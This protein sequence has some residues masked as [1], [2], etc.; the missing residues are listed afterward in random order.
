M[1][2]GGGG[3]GRP[4]CANCGPGNAE[5]RAAERLDQLNRIKSRLIA[6]RLDTNKFIS[7]CTQSA[8]WLG[9]F[10]T[11]TADY[12]D[13]L[14]TIAN[15]WSSLSDA[16]RALFPEFNTTNDIKQVI[17]VY[18][19]V[20]KQLGAVIQLAKFVTSVY[21]PPPKNTA[22]TATDSEDDSSSSTT[23]EEKMN[24]D[25]EAAAA[26]TDEKVGQ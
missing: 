5:R 21:P 17:N 3:C 19:S 7:E 26:T 15:N 20:V 4:G 8:E 11:A 25:A 16:E 22:T 18:G 23:S 14:E 6:N 9:R 13:E 2:G 10:A 12:C 24:T 1:A